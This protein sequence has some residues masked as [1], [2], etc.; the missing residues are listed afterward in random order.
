MQ[1]KFTHAILGGTFDHFHAGHR[2]FIEAALYQSNTL[3]IG[4]T[5]KKM[6]Q[7]KSFANTIESYEI[8]EKNINNYSSNV[9]LRG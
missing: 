9:M 4:L 8:R 1:T 2:H 6:Y 7:H 5:T 3:V